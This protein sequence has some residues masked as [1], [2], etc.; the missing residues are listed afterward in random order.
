MVEGELEPVPIELLCEED[1]DGEG[2]G[3]EEM[4]LC[5]LC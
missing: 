1:L 4:E 3:R 2:K 5:C